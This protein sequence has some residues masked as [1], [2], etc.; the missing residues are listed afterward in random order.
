MRD[1]VRPLAALLAAAGLMGPGSALA[2][3]VDTWPGVAAFVPFNTAPFPYAGIVPDTGRPFLDVVAGGRRGHSSLRGGVYWEAETYSDNRSLVYVPAGFDPARPATLVVFFH[4][5]EATL[6]DDV[7]ERQR[8]AAQVYDSGLNAVLVA[9]QFAIDALDSSAGRFWQAGAFGAYLR[10][11][12]NALAA[13][14]G[15]P[16]LASAFRRMPVVLAAYSGGY[17]PAAYSASVG[18][19]GARLCGLALFD[20]VYGEEPMFASWI[21][22]KPGAG[23]FF[24]AYSESAESGNDTLQYELDRRHI[25]YARTSRPRLTPGSVTFV[26]AGPV[27]HDSFMTRAWR[28]DPLEWLLGRLAAGGVCQG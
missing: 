7:V 8:I 27:D 18:G 21:A 2:Q 9:P 3:P 1:L 28:A 25:A 15:D 19:A 16:T 17:L 12:A 20:A 6:A 14:A 5:N 23:F 4:G 11:A 13:V 26:P 10:E 22:R 24:S